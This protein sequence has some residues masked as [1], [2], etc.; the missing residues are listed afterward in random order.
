MLKKLHVFLL[1][2][3]LVLAGCNSDEEATKDEDNM[4]NTETE[5]N[6]ETNSNDNESNE[7]DLEE[8]LYNGFEPRDDLDEQYFKI[9]ADLANWNSFVIDYRYNT[10]LSDADEMPQEI[11]DTSRYVLEPFQLHRWY[12]SIY[13]KNDQIELYANENEAYINHQ[14]EEWEKE[15]DPSIYFGNPLE[16]RMD[17][18]YSFIL[19]SYGIVEFDYGAIMVDILP[20]KFEDVYEQI[21]LAFHHNI[22]INSAEY[23][24]AVAT[25]TEPLN[26]LEGISIEISIEDDQI[27]GVNILISYNRTNEE[28]ID[29]I[30]ITE[31]YSEINAFDTI[32]I[33]A[34][35]Y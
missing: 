1:L 9:I 35:V 31:Q 27:T 14:M 24:S 29:Q 33:P 28:T 26:E 15:D 12:H 2:A 8:V 5:E 32:E 7:E 19:N 34:E 25:L 20:E 6:N 3:S 10:F 23:A 4:I 16:S 22:A 30:H 11:N 21:Q 13:F 17:L 18:F